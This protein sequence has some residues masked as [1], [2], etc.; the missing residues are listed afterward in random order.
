M[1]EHRINPEKVTTPIQLLAAWLVGL[2][3]IDSCFLFAATQFDAESWQSGALTVAAIV[4]VPLFIGAVFLLQTRFRPELQE[5]SYYSTYLNQK[6]N[7]EISILAVP[8]TEDSIVGDELDQEGPS[9]PMASWE[10]LKIGVNENLANGKRID[11]YLASRG[12]LT[13]STFGENSDPPE[14]MKIAIKRSLPKQQVWDI[15][16][17]AGALDF[18]YFGYIRD[19][20]EISEDVLFGAYGSPGAVIAG[21]AT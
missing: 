2:L 3:T 19:E 18:E 21:R 11:E 4:N 7:E 5:D 15:I 1:T 13:Y 17:A 10:S 6:T 8:S 14:L 12:V 16:E 20:E 9:E